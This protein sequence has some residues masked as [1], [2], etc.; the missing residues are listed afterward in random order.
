MTYDR[1]LFTCLGDTE[2]KWVKIG[3]GEQISVKGKESIAI[4]SYTGFKVI[5][6][7]KCY[8]IRYPKSLEMFKIKM[9]NILIILIKLIIILM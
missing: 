3:N 7:D 5:F 1:E 4:T 8:I 9:N 6:E 2:I